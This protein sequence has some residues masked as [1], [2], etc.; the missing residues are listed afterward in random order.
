MRRLMRFDVAG[1]AC[2]G[3]LDEAGKS[4]G[5]LCITGGT[6]TRSGAHRMLQELAVAV[7][8]AG[9]P[10]FRY[11][12]RG[13]GDSEGE[14]LGFEASGADLAAALSCFR[15]ALPLDRVIGFGLCDGATTLALH[16]SSSDFAGLL[17]A[18][19]WFVEAASGDPP[20]AALRAH[21]SARLLDPA[22][23][24][25]LLRGGVNIG[26][27]IASVR[28]AADT[29]TGVLADRVASALAR[30]DGPVRLVLSERDATAIAAKACWAGA[31]FEKVRAQGEL[32][33]I[34]TDAHTFARDSDGAAL[35]AHVIGFLERIDAQAAAT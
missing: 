5:L 21:Y 6:Q 18:N 7:A 12:R 14:D 4:T 10:V 34:V 30:F 29:D 35:A 11:D 26:A 24:A 13:T 17:L 28:K 20:P 32:V 33:S 3:S 9:H 31:G 22:A 25:R 1:D 8:S 16:A 2:G 15:D 23:W 19:P 27:A